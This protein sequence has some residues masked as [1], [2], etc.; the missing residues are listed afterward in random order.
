MGGGYQARGRDGDPVQGLGQVFRPGADQDPAKIRASFRDFGAGSGA[1]GLQGHVRGAWVG[2][3][4][5]VRPVRRR[6]RNAQ[7]AL[8]DEW[9]RRRLHRGRRV[10]SRSTLIKERLGN[11]CVADRVRVL[12]DRIHS[13]REV[14][15]QIAKEGILLG[16]DS[17]AFLARSVPGQQDLSR[18]STVSRG[19]DGAHAVLTVSGSGRL[20]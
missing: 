19:H 5:L 16:P 1:G 7:L 3:R 8:G 14:R 17:L 9:D 10:R 6:L 12:D 11:R 2:H 18:F 20:P 4:R 13:E 15:P